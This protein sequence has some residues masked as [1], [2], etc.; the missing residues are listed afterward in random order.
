M[1]WGAVFAT[2]SP[3]GGRVG[4]IQ[5]GAAGALLSEN[6]S[7]SFAIARGTENALRK[8]AH[9]IRTPLASIMQCVDALLDMPDETSEPASR[10]FDILRR[11]VLWMGQMLD[12]SGEERRVPRQE[13][14]L[15]AVASDVVALI[16]PL[17]EIRQQTLTIDCR[18]AKV[19]IRADHAGL[20]RALLNLID[21]ASKYGP[22]GDAIRVAIRRRRHSTIVSVRDH[23]PGIPLRER[24]AVF[25]AFYRTPEMRASSHP[26][27]GLGLAV[28]R[29]FVESHGGSVGAG[30]VRGETRVWFCLP[31]R[32]GPDT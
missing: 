6:T 28:V 3:R 8:A 15:S 26:G 5:V 13:I 2:C 24:R 21:N 17:L 11:N 30:R 20:A 18:P 9:D 25:S 23:G 7:A 12:I 14:E 1:R 27:I 32:E 29:E 4:S 10:L 22:A 16:G 31:D 19:Q